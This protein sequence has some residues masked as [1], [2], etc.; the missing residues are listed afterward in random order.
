[1]EFSRELRP[2][3]GRPRKNFAQRQQRQK[4]L[5]T[6]VSD[7]VRGKLG[8]QIYEF[9]I[10]L[11]LSRANLAR[12]MTVT[13]TAIYYWEHGKFE[14]SKVVWASFCRVR[15]NYRRKMKRLGKDLDGGPVMGGKLLKG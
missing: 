8:E 2:P 6:V 3:K 9:R 4:R 10:S 15:E 11:G 12:L 5:H 13:E 14:P 7:R 1:M